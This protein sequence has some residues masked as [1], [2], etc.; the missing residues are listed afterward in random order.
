MLNQYVIQALQ[1]EENRKTVHR[2]ELLDSRTLVEDIHWQSSR[3]DSVATELPNRVELSSEED[4]DIGS[5]NDFYIIGEIPSVETVEAGTK[6]RK[7]PQDTDTAES[8]GPDEAS[9]VEILSEEDTPVGPQDESKGTA[10][11]EAGEEKSTTSPKAGELVAEPSELETT[12]PRRSTRNTA[13]KPPNPLNF[14]RS[15]LQQEATNNTTMQLDPS[16]IA[17]ITRT[18]LLLVQLLSNS[19][20]KWRKTSEMKFQLTNIIYQNSISIVVH[21]ITV[22]SKYIFL[23]IFL[24]EHYFVC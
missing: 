18:Q 14:P 11:Y 15:V 1:G 2:K 5:E 22:M 9:A 12:P 20:Q 8:V 16:V 19:V 6:G 24:K 21:I 17:D 10:S 13:G 7:V 3:E 4:D 23:C